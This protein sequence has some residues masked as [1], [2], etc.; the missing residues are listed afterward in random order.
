MV[1]TSDVGSGVVFRLPIIAPHS[2][3]SFSVHIIDTSETI[4][5]DY[6][7]IWIKALWPDVAEIS[8]SDAPV[9]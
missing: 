7:G 8:V 9:F 4:T 6:I 5:A 3:S 2:I 1:Y